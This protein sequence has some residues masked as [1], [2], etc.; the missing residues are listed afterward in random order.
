MIL[1]G[2]CAGVI[3]FLHL[4][5]LAHSIVF[6]VG[7][8]NATARIRRRSQYGKLD[9]QIYVIL[10]EQVEGSM[11]VVMSGNAVDDEDQKM[12]PVS[13]LRFNETTPRHPEGVRRVIE[14]S[15][16]D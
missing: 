12:N 16:N 8:P 5:E 3:F 13:S 10:D 9:G 14:M 15:V 7:Q 6:L 1:E 11:H 4:H 2:D